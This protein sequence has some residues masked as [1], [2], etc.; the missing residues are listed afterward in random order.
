MSWENFQRARVERGAAVLRERRKGRT[1]QDIGDEMGLT[2]QR[3]RQ[4][5]MLAES[6]EG[7]A[8]RTPNLPPPAV[9]PRTLSRHTR[10]RLRRCR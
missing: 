9:T 6:I 7:R 3:V 2:K 10:S 8:A 5:V 4:L 1:F